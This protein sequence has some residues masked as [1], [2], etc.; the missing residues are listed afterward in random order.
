VPGC[1]EASSSWR[2]CPQSSSGTPRLGRHGGGRC[3]SCEARPSEV[4]GGRSSN[5]TVPSLSIIST[6]CPSGSVIL[7]SCAISSALQ[8]IMP[9]FGKHDVRGPGTRNADVGSRSTDIV[10][11]YSWST[12]ARTRPPTWAGSNNSNG[13][14]RPG[15]RSHIND[16]LKEQAIF[17]TQRRMFEGLINDNKFS[18]PQLSEFTERSIGRYHGQGHP[19]HNVLTSSESEYVT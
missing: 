17:S 12:R 15:H 8:C 9:R 2:S 6:L 13:E 4:W 18:L 11:P 5:T 3:S 16:R 19:R 7:R 14:R 10:T 1:S